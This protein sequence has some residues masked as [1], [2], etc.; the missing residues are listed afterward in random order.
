MSTFP[1]PQPPLVRK[2]WKRIGGVIFEETPDPSSNII[3]HPV[4]ARSYRKL[5]KE[6]RAIDNTKVNHSIQEFDSNR[7]VGKRGVAVRAG[8]QPIDGCWSHLRRHMQCLLAGRNQ[9][10][11]GALN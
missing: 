7:Y 6:W 1:R 8:T 3:L 2:Q 10:Q 9:E 5:E 11:D 4:G